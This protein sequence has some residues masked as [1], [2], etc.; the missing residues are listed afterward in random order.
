MFTVHRYVPLAQMMKFNRL[1][2]NEANKSDL[3]RFY[4]LERYGGIWVDCSTFMTAPL[5]WLPEGFFC[6]NARRFSK[7][8]HVCLEN[9]FIKSP[10]GHPFITRWRRQTEKDFADPDFKAN[11]AKYRA[12][13]G[14]N[15]DYLVPYVSSLKLDK[16]GIHYEA[17]EDGP[18]F[19]TVKAGWRNPSE[20]CQNISYSTK[21]VSCST[22]RAKSV[23]RYG[24]IN[25]HF[26]RLL[27]GGCVR[28]F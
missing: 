10:K 22:Q 19:D 24:S 27:A 1:T 16:S 14:K 17:S 13:I 6:Y 15:A 18:Y 12:M 9:F 28:P 25:S 2:S 8:G 3:I 11:N 20:M 4:L 26:C 23:H 5:D 7:N 21:I